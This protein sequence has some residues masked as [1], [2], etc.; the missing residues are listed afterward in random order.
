MYPVKAHH[1]GGWLLAVAAAL[2][3]GSQPLL[4]AHPDAHDP[5]ALAEDPRQADGRIA[6]VL[7]GLGENHFPVTTS[8]DEAQ[9]FFDQGLLLTYGFNHQEALRAFKEAARL[10]PDLAMAYWG[11]ALVLGPNLNLAMSA[12]AGAQAYEA[13]RLALERIDGA[14][15]KE[16]RLIEALATRYGPDPEAAR[17]TL[18]AAY[19]EA[20]AGVY[21]RY[22]E[23]PDV[24]TLYASALMNTSPWNYWTP[25]GRP[26]ENTKTIAE[27]LEKVIEQDPHHEGALHYYIHLVEPVDPWRGERAADLLRGLAPAAGHLVHMPSHIYMQ[28][29][30]YREAYEANVHAAEADEDYFTQCL[31]QG[32]YPLTYYPHNV[33]FLV[34]AAAMDG[35]RADALEAAR[36]VAAH[37]PEDREGDAWALF[38]TFSSMPLSTMVRF[39][40]WREIL[41]EPEPRADEPFLTGIWHYARGMA[42]LRTRGAGPATRELRKLQRIERDRRSAEVVIGFSDASSLLTI[43]SELLGA[44]I[45]AERGRYHSALGRAE[46]ALRVEDALQYNEPPAWFAPVR[47]T[48]GALL[49]EAGLPREAETVFYQDLEH[50]PENGYAL[51][52]LW[53]AL[54]AQGRHSEALAVRERFEQTWRGADFAITGSRS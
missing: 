1:F 6:P 11:W 53:Q 10:D 16:R 32:I 26:R 42:L 30:R 22:P 4:A 38:E 3:A 13:I 39:G 43:A 47:H 21:G 25:E 40:M 41:A 5:R 33:H 48:L 31:S 34:W 23:D 18:D 50:N 20:M 52:G 15:D 36:K 14:G 44:E 29:G 27:V 45:D 49:L 28:V 46:R 19:A 37:V 12:E 54:A 9:R 51:Y 2:A 17:A 35:R 7:E 24:A 8:S